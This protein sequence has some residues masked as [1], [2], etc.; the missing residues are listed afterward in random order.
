M[1]DRRPRELALLSDPALIE[2]YRD[3]G[4][5]LVTPEKLLAIYQERGTCAA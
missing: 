5:R 3:A 2:A 1:V 4:F